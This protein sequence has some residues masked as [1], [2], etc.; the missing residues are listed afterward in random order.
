MKHLME[1]LEDRRL[2]SAS[3]SISVTTGPTPPTVP[4]LPMPIEPVG[5]PVAVHA[6]ATDR[7]TATIATLPDTGIYSQ[8]IQLRTLLGTIT[9]GD[10]TPTSSAS[11][12][13]GSDGLIHVLGTHTYA[14]SGH[15]NVSVSLEEFT[16]LGPVP[17]F[18]P[19]PTV[20]GPILFLGTVKTTAYVTADN[21][22]GVSLTE[23]AGKSFTAQI[24]SFDFRGIDTFIKQVVI[25]WGD[26]HTST[27]TLKGGLLTTNG[28]YD[29]FGT[30]TYAHAGTYKVHVTV[31][32][33]LAG[34]NVISGTVADFFSTIKVVD[35]A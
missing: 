23:I 12:I 9:W 35:A 15:Y 17:P 13:R 29:V 5:K 18:S 34:S 25:N 8:T 7:F 6:E 26:G 16:N 22:G 19:L 1:A 2:M 4:W 32:S 14:H 24:G 10:G 3:P 31:I 20:V 33:A 27:G 30:H 11:F 28:E 21:D